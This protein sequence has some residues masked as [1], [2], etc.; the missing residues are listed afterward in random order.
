MVKHKGMSDLCLTTGLEHI[1]N[2]R[3]GS[4]RP[5]TVWQGV[6]GCVGKTSPT[7]GCPTTSGTRNQIWC[8]AGVYSLSLTFLDSHRLN[9]VRLSLTH[10]IDFFPS[11]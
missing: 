10:S 6:S 5:M 1:Q 4:S 8:T 3:Y 7:H 2:C 11:G 9:N